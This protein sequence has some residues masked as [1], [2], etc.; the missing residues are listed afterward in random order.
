MLVV[1]GLSPRRVLETLKKCPVATESIIIGGEG[2]DIFEL[3]I[4][5]LFFTLLA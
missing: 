2:V 3:I 4:W 5:L 1:V